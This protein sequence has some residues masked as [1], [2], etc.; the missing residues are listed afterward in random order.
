MEGTPLPE[1]TL[2]EVTL[3]EEDLSVQMTRCEKKTLQPYAMEQPRRICGE[4]LLQ[5][6]R[7]MLESE[8]EDVYESRTRILCEHGEDLECYEC[9][10]ISTDSSTSS[11]PSLAREVDR[12][13]QRY[14]RIP[15]CPFPYVDWQALSRPSW[16]D[17]VGLP[18]PDQLPILSCSPVPALYKSRAWM[19]K[20]PSPFGFLYG[21]RTT[22]GPVSMPS[23]LVNGYSWC[24]EEGAWRIAAF[25]PSRRRR[26]GRRGGQGRHLRGG[27]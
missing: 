16:K 8:E 19:E 21:H 14:P 12:I 18:K 5:S 22:M 13:A 17:R 27:G 26:G 6:E 20:D 9:A 15:P 2:P 23:C 11:I 24:Q 7:D 25:P 4:E 3:Q 10:P 1:V